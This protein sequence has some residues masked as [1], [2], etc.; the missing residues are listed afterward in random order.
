MRSPRTSTREAGY[1]P[2]ISRAL[3]RLTGLFV[4]LSTVSCILNTV[5]GNKAAAYHYEVRKL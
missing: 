4:V 3:F 2:M 5:P 1:F